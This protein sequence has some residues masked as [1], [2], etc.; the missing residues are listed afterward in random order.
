M[1]KLDCPVDNKKEI[2][3]LILSHMKMRY[4]VKDYPLCLTEIRVL[5]VHLKLLKLQVILKIFY[6]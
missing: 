6:W 3:I 1:K 4:R 2:I 5:R